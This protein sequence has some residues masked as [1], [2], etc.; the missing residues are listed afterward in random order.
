LIDLYVSDSVVIKIKS[1]TVKVSLLCRKRK[2]LTLSLVNVSK[3]LL[4]P[5]NKEFPLLWRFIWLLY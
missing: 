4:W 3:Q 5:L 1:V 2:V